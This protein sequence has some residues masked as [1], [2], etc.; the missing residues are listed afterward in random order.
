MRLYFFIVLQAS[1]R[2]K[3]P[4][5]ITSSEFLC[6][7]SK[8]YSLLSIRFGYVKPIIITMPWWKNLLI[9]I[10]SLKS[11]S[12]RKIANSTA[13]CRGL[14]QFDSKSCCHEVEPPCRRL[15]IL[16][17]I[18]FQPVL[19]LSPHELFIIIVLPRFQIWI[20][21]IEVTAYFCF[22]VVL[23]VFRKISVQ[24]KGDRNVIDSRLTILSYWNRPCCYAEL[25]YIFNNKT[26]KY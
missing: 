18:T 4:G 3:I 14:N 21:M 11:Y 10:E 22:N 8:V 24:W 12:R 15:I 13:P 16:N 20:C 1:L 6:S 23:T 19:W 9:S 2:N 7:G 17:L 26:V 25:F 5:I